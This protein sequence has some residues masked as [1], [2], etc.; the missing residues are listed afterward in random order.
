MET[1]EAVEQPEDSGGL[2]P[3]G[4]FKLGAL[5]I[6]G[7]AG[8]LLFSRV[9]A[10]LV[11]MSLASIVP[12]VAYHVLRKPAGSR[13]VFSSLGPEE[14]R[15]EAR[16]ASV[17]ISGL[18]MP[19]G[20]GDESEPDAGTSDPVEFPVFLEQESPESLPVDAESERSPLA[21]DWLPVSANTGRS[22]LSAEEWAASALDEIEDNRPD[23][24]HFGDQAIHEP[25]D[26]TG[27]PDRDFN[28]VTTVFDHWDPS[29]CR[30]GGEMLFDSGEAPPASQLLE[31]I[32]PEADGEGPLESTCDQAPAVIESETPADRI[33]VAKQASERGEEVGFQA[34]PRAPRG[35]DG[36]MA[37]SPYRRVPMDA[38]LTPLALAKSGVQI[39]P[40]TEEEAY[41]AFSEPFPGRAVVGVQAVE[42]PFARGDKEQPGN[43]NPGALASVLL[44]EKRKPGIKVVRGNVL[45]GRMFMVLSIGVILSGGAFLVRK[46]LMG[47]DG[48]VPGQ[49]LLIAPEFNGDPRHGAQPIGGNTTTR[50]EHDFPADTGVTTSTADEKVI[51]DEDL[52]SFRFLE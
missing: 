51:D 19:T 3:G 34:T 5:A 29:P 38:N 46:A 26:Q 48:Y 1:P 10:G 30:S 15:P 40:L 14:S 37:R 33:P 50:E 25:E 18:F 17:E 22:S 36:G 16:T 45:L 42:N 41:D 12:V 35:M 2:H 13:K 49:S 31:R 24:S 20:K 44:Q 28:Q 8:G 43:N 9:I 23:T 39:K 11:R 52:P 32:E 21:E 7:L 4:A 47:T 27:L 6:S